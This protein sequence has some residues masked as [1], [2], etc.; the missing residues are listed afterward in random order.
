VNRRL[1]KNILVI[2]AC[3]VLYQAFVM[4]VIQIWVYR[5][6]DFLIY[7]GPLFHLSV[8]GEGDGIKA[9]RNIT[10][11]LHHVREDSMPVRR[12][13]IFI[14]DT[15]AIENIGYEGMVSFVYP[16]VS[17]FWRFDRYLPSLFSDAPIVNAR[18]IV[19]SHLGD[20]RRVG[21]NESK[22]F[23]GITSWQGYHEFIRSGV[24][25]SNAAEPNPLLDKTVLL[26][27]FRITGSDLLCSQK[28]YSL[29]F[30][31]VIDYEHTFLYTQG[32][33]SDFFDRETS[34]MYGARGFSAIEDSNRNSS[35][36]AL[37]IG[38][39]IENMTFQL[40]ANGVESEI[41]INELMSLDIVRTETD[42][43]SA[44]DTLVDVIEWLSWY[45]N[46]AMLYTNEADYNQQYSISLKD[47][48]SDD[49]TGSKVRVPFGYD[50]YDL[51]IGA[52]A[53]HL[54]CRYFYDSLNRTII[55]DSRA[56]YFVSYD[57]FD[58]SIGFVVSLMIE[59][60]RVF[61]IIVDVDLSSSESMNIEYAMVKAASYNNIGCNC[62]NFGINRYAKSVMGLD[63]INN[64]DQG[65]IIESASVTV[66]GGRPFR[67][68]IGF[69]FL[70]RIMK[71]ELD[72]DIPRYFLAY[73]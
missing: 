8:I 64:Q 9:T 6:S 15:Y 46:I 23:T 1:K 5:D 58:S 28:I 67:S 60:I 43:K 25:L 62:H 35:F 21:F 39:D 57:I 56:E 61:Y 37:V 59:W 40:L 22:H 3:I 44:I 53:D 16:F 55:L 27:A 4:L 7:S 41:D 13:D 66:S 72:M 70:N 26:Y 20:S 29:R 12:S 14:R 50:L 17:S 34:T 63:F 69:R 33:A 68:N 42:L 73:R 45:I 71:A 52:L 18:L 49:C 36:Y 2:L 47:H 10:I 31:F 24:H 51:M 11:D 65:F 30:G 54:N 19:G 32:M 38:N 48:K